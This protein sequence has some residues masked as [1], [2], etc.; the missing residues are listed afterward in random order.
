MNRN[1]FYEE[2]TTWDELI[3]FC[4]DHCIESVVSDIYDLEDV[5]EY[6]RDLVDEC[7]SSEAIERIQYAVRH[8]SVWDEYYKL[9][10][11][12]FYGVDDDDFAAYKENA[13]ETYLYYNDW[14]TS[15]C[16]IDVDANSN[17]WYGECDESDTDQANVSTDEWVELMNK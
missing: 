4:E 10:G 7:S 9:Y 17:G 3:G 12:E 14:D 1:E 8:L 16:D 6:I 15:S 5:V 13:E 2:V 11:N